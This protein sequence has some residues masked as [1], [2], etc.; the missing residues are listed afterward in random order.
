[1]QRLICPVVVWVCVA[2]REGQAC[3]P[4]LAAPL[5]TRPITVSSV[6]T[7]QRH[8]VAA[9]AKEFRAP[10]LTSAVRVLRMLA[11]VSDSLARQS[12]G[13]FGGTGERRPRSSSAAP[14]T[15]KSASSISSQSVR[16]GATLTA[17][18]YS[19]Q[20]SPRPTTMRQSRSL[21]SRSA[22]HTRETR[23]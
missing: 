23:V 12:G 9:R 4:R 20:E 10:L 17:N 18:E 16:L 6:S 19:T 11:R 2:C 8:C 21:N 15:I 5:F 22:C 7:L 1:M 14:A 3:P 13:R